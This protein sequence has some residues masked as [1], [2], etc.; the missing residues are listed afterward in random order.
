MRVK[1]IIVNETQS[2]KLSYV[3][4]DYQ[5]RNKVRNLSIA[6]IKSYKETF[7]IFMEQVIA[8]SLFL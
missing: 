8:V 4:E 2:R 7:S 1:R 5:V 3:L 6:S